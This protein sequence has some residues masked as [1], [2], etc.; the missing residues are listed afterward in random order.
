MKNPFSKK[1]KQQQSNASAP[2][3]EAEAP[4]GETMK[5]P[6]GGYYDKTCAEYGTV[7][8]ELAELEQQL[9]QAQAECGA[10]KGWPA[11]T[12]LTARRQLSWPTGG[13]RSF[14]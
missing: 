9:Q 5:F 4:T 6:A 11:S 14:H 1:S 3:I 7:C 12:I 10:K 13:G 2:V 8:R